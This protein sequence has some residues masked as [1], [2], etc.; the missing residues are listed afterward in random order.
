MTDCHGVIGHSPMSGPS[1]D[2]RRRPSSLVIS[3][4]DPLTVY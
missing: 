1:P 4:A 3:Y 2:S